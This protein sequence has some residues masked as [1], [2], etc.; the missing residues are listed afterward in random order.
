MNWNGWPMERVLIL[1][2]T[3]AY[4]LIGIQVTMYHYRQNFHHKSMYIPVF[5]FPVFVVV[6]LILT[7]YNN[8]VIQLCFGVLMA[9]GMVVGLVGAYLHFRGIGVRVGSYRMLRNYLI[10]PPVILPLL[11][12]AVGALGLIALYWP[13]SP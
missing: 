4:L 13:D 5:L 9:I 3:L 8:P 10:G 2:V 7:I 11:F 1:F 6:G 12:L